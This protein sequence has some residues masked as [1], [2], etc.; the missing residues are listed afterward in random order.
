MIAEFKFKIPGATLIRE[1]QDS[2]LWTYKGK[3]EKFSFLLD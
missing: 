2:E 1:V 3:Y